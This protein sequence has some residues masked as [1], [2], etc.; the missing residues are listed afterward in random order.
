M[1]DRDFFDLLYQQWTK[2]TKAETAFW[3]P[4]DTGDG[5][6]DIAA[7]G[8]DDSRTVV[9][10]ALSEADADW[11][12]GVH[13][14]FGELVRRL[15]EAVDEAERFECERDQAMLDWSRDAEENVHLRA[16]LDVAR[17][18]RDSARANNVPG[19]P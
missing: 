11:I 13:G 7:V 12:T 9:A 1:E 10:S 4:Q 5:S 8:Q 14:C 3:A 6:W 19:S 16:A 17:A 15:Q 18:E 2:T